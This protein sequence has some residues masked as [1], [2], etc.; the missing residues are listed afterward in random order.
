M[1]KCQ[2]NGCTHKAVLLVGDCK[3]CSGHYCGSHR[4]PEDHHCSGMDEC[5]KRHF[6][7]NKKTLL[8]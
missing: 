5:R 6:E 4:L 3:Y 8:D 1:V 2:C 7:K